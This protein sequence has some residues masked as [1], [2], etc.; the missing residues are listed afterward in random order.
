MRY[1]TIAVLSCVL[2]AACGGGG[3]VP[4]SDPGG[5]TNPPPTGSTAATL[6]I[7]TLSDCG[8]ESLAELLRVIDIFQSLLNPV[9]TPPAL[10]ISG[11]DNSAKVI[12]WDFDTDGDQQP[13]MTGAFRFVDKDDNPA[14]VDLSGVQSLGLTALLGALSQMPDL[15]RFMMEFNRATASLSAFGGLDLLYEGGLPTKVNG[16]VEVQTTTCQSVYILEDVALTGL[17]NT[18][19]IPTAVI[20]TLINST[21]QLDGTV[22][23]NGTNT[24]RFDVTVDGAD[25][26][27]INYDIPSKTFTDITGS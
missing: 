19:G 2:V 21:S 14:A 12:S 3:T 20:R 1:F 13:D 27:S 25:N 9:G 10:N 15:G 16:S 26:V 23:F 17:L 7:E 5:N 8:P 22:T 18:T 4:A 6:A 11:V 24:V